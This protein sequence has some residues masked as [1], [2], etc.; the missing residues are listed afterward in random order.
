VEMK[1]DENVYV[2]SL[3]KNMRNR[4]PIPAQL[5]KEKECWMLD[6]SFCTTLRCNWVEMVKHYVT[7]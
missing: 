5:K 3:K 1:D 7:R 4:K 2:D 6:V